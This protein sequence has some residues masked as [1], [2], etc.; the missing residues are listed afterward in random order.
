VLPLVPVCVEIG[1]GSGYVSAAVY[2]RLHS[3]RRLPLM[4][5]TDINAHAAVAARQTMLLN[6]V[7]SDTRK[8]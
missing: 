6:Q 8:H 2:Q 1:C 7:S 5:L 4:I 3:L